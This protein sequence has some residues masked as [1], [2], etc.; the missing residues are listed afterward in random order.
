MVINELSALC[1]MFQFGV[2][3]ESVNCSL[4]PRNPDAIASM[5]AKVA[6]KAGLTFLI[7]ERSAGTVPG[8]LSKP[9][10]A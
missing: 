3:G 6:D 7:R 5:R 2:V 8:G 9:S 10:P 1:L 4:N